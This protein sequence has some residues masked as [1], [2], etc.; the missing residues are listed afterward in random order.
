MASFKLVLHKPNKRKD[1]TYPISLRIIKNMRTKYFNLGLYTTIEE[2]DEHAERFKQDKKICP[3]YKEYNAR[4]LELQARAQALE[5]NFDREGIDWTLEQFKNAFFHKTKQ[6]KFIEYTNKCINDMKGTGHIGNAKVW[7][8]SIYNL[9]LYDKRLK[10]RLLSEIDIKYVNNY[11][12]F[13]EKKGW[14]GNTRKH[15]IKTLRAIL[16]KAIQEKE[17]SPNNYPFGKG[18]FCVSALGEETRKRFLSEESLS[19]L[20]N[21]Q[22]KSISKEIARRLFIFSYLCYGMSF[23]DMANIKKENIIFE[24]GKEYI[25]YKRQKTEHCK[26]SKYIKILMSDDIK[27]LIKWFTENTNLIGKYLLPVVTIN[28][29]GEKLYEHQRRRLAKYNSNL[30]KL[31]EELDIPEKLTSYV[32]RHSMAMSLQKDGTPREVISQIMGHKDL[33][34]TNTYLDSFSNDVIEKATNKSLYKNKIVL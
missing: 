6:G 23:I 10:S 9:G 16:N 19:K 34:T 15:N 7:E 12:I 21:T 18:G 27:V 24:G 20:M 32:S 17:C 28:Y 3:M 1:G 2:W 29:T 8:S 22:S 30:K 33:S 14:C 11:N 31:G 13:M 26:G 25:M 4:L 5:I